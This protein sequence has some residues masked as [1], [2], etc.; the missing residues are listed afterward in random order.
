MDY[1]AIIIGSGI[2]GLYAGLKL[3]QFTNK[4][5]LTF[6]DIVRD[7][8]KF[9]DYENKL[10]NLKYPYFVV[11]DIIEKTYKVKTFEVDGYYTTKTFGDLTLTINN[12][13]IKNTLDYEM[14][15]SDTYKLEKFKIDKNKKLIAFSYDDGPSEYDYQTID[16]LKKVKFH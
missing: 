6:N 1:S 4:K 13:V 2:S 16:I 10:L 11:N 9:D 15:Y 3:Q 8:N 5:V 14:K 7:K 12:N